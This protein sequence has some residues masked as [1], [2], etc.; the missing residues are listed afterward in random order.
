MILMSGLSQNAAE[1]LSSEK[2]YDDHIPHFCNIMRFAV[3]K[4]DHALMAIGG[5]W[6]TVDEGDPSSVD[7]SS[8]VRTVLRSVLSCINIILL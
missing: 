6:D 7:D 1:E 4:K 2:S 8:L 5:P 3:L